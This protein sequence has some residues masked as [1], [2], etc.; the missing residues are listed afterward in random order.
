MVSVKKTGPGH[1]PATGSVDD[2]D[3]RWL[4]S[5][6]DARPQAE[7]ELLARA[8]E[9]ARRAHTGQQRHSGEPYLSH[10]LAVA[11]ILNDLNLDYET[12]AAALLHDTVEDTT[13]TLT[14][15]EKTFGAPV[16]RLVDGVTKMGRIGRLQEVQGGRREQQDAESLRKLLLAM[17]DDVRVVLIKLADRLHNMRTLKY[18]DETRQVQIARETLDIYAPLANRLGIGQIKWELEDLS[19]RYIDADSYREIAAHLDERRIDRERFIDRVVRQLQRELEAVGVQAE[20]SGR[21]KHIYSIWRKMQ[22]KNLPFNQIFDVR[23]VRIIV[24]NDAD[25][26]AALGVVHSLW[27]HIP[28]E[29][30]DYIANPKENNYRSLHT[31]VVGPGGQTME[32]QIRSRD[33]HEH[34]ELG[35]AAHWH[36]KEGGRFDSGIEQRVAWLR[37]LLEW[38]DEESTASD[39]VD[40][41]K[42]ESGGER[43]YVLTPQGRVVDLPQGATPL[44]FAYYVHT[45]IGHRCRGAKINGRI[46]PLTYELHNGEQVE[47]LTTRLGTPSRDWLNVHLGFLKTSRARAKVRHWFRQQDYD[48]NVAAGR[49]V[50]DRELNRLGM[51]NCNW[52][53][54]AERLHCPNVSDMLSAIGN[55]DLS[56]AQLA[57]AAN[58]LALPGSE[59][60]VPARPARSVD[61]GDTGLRIEGVGNLLTQIAKCCRPVPQDP[62]IGYITRGRGVTIHRRDCPNVLRMAAEERERL[63]EV[64]WGGA[65]SEVYPVEIEILAFDR[66]GLLRDI[67]S[68][69]ANEKVNVIGVNTYTDKTDYAAHMRLTL[70]IRDIGELSRVLGRILG[71][72]CS[73]HWATG[74]MDK[75]KSRNVARLLGLAKAWRIPV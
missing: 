63:L 36:Y 60:F 67:T 28:K 48:K 33:M 42:S 49:T 53:N 55:G 68:V 3:A 54:L 75:Q 74:A 46:V 26:Y 27:H 72:G 37:Q 50:L 44:D 18:L 56:T 34:A 14:D 10:V 58:E 70:E 57:G 35:I 52:E 23:A 5:L 8:L 22:R 29:F 25:C 64:D 32:V 6:A 62:I 15:I 66:S 59:E 11:E 7:R 20:V 39:F 21:P 38:K 9:L 47:I 2:S 12:L 19:L 45:D 65:A 16:A 30:D 69:L 24:E 43:V 41:F 61:A 51:G 73:I 13:V 4:R 1:D 17:V 31:A 40:R 71:G